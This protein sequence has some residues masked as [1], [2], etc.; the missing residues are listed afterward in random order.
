MD[1][2]TLCTVASMLLCQMCIHSSNKWL[3]NPSHM[4]GTVSRTD[5]DTHASLMS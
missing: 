1:T 4:P 2:V 5:S 3:L